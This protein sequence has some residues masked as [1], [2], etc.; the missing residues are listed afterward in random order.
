MKVP[1]EIEGIKRRPPRRTINKQQAIRHLVHAAVRMIAAHE[2]PFAIHLVIQSADKLL[3]D[4]AKAM[5]K[6][7]AHDWFDPV[8]PEYRKLLAAIFRETY[9]YLKHA[10]NDHDEPLHV[11]SIAQSNVIQLGVCVANYHHLFG[12][13]TDHM[14]LLFTMGAMLVFPDGFVNSKVRAAF[15]KGVPGLGEMRFGEFFDGELWQQASRSSEFPNLAREREVDLQD[16]AEL[17]STRIR[18]FGKEA[19]AR[20]IRRSEKP[21]G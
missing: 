16:N 12:E 7:L 13:W 11:G 17:F 5:G 14:R 19:A 18:D 4:L 9:N 6:P 10:D 2:D 15:D 21:R 3:G 20:V 8:K 1:K